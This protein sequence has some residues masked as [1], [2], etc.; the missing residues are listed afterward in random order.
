MPFD[1]LFNIYFNV[2]TNGS[3]IL[4]QDSD[5]T[6]RYSSTNMIATNGS[7]PLYNT[8]NLTSPSVSSMKSTSNNL[9]YP[10]VAIYSASQS[11]LYDTS[12]TLLKK[13]ES[14]QGKTD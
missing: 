2:R 3:N 13:F 10:S 8:N 6:R 11:Q 4:A 12:P 9:K 14:H 7:S 1:T 5:R